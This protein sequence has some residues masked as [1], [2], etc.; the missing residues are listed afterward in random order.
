PV[1]QAARRDPH[2]TVLP[3]PERRAALASAARLV[4][5]DALARVLER[6][7]GHVRIRRVAPD[8][9]ERPAG[10][11]GTEEAELA[12]GVQAVDLP[13]APQVP[14]G[15]V[16]AGG[17]DPGDVEPLDRGV[18]YDLHPVVGEPPVSVR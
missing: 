16:V 1:T 9:N 7:L 13:Y 5:D 2:A 4:G 15:A 18:G 14:I 12:V 17:L 8:E 11:P 6:H 3:P 10:G